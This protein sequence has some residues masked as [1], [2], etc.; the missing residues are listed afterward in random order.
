M[1][2]SQDL[3]R[4]LDCLCYIYRQHAEIGEVDAITSEGIAELIEWM[5]KLIIGMTRGESL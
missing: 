5:V 3:L 1:K 4:M 2:T